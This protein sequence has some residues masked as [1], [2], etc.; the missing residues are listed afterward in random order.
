[1]DCSPPGY[2]VHGI[3]QA[4]I[5]EW[6]AISFSRESFQPRD[7]TH[8]SCISSWI[9]YH[10]AT[11]G[12]KNKSKGPGGT[13]RENMRSQLDRERAAFPLSEARKRNQSLFWD[14]TLEVIISW[15]LRISYLGTNPPGLSCCNLTLPAAR[16]PIATEGVNP[17]KTMC[18]NPIGSK[19]LS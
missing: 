18:C 4:W 6:V 16:R 1:M 9:L 15:P 8:V 13:S 14:M 3:F 19:W 10:W 7:W 17:G 11:R 2:S 12:K 5:L